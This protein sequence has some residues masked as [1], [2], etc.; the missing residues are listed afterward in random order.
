MSAVVDSPH[1]A[2][3]PMQEADIAAVMVNELAAYEYP[4]TE[5]ILRDC[6]RVGYSC[7]VLE[8]EHGISGHAVLSLMAA[9]ECH[10]LNLCVAPA[11]QGRGLGRA[12]LSHLLDLARERGVRTALLEVRPSNTAALALYASVGF[13]EIG[14]RKAYYPAKRGREDGLILAL[15]LT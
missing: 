9:G 3:R 2:L 13:N 6:L 14:S 5:G 4:W 10:I 15:E 11:L 8:T 12:L 1:L 7:W